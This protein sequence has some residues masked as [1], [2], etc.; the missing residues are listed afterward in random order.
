M[1]LAAPSFEYLFAPHTGQVLLDLYEPATHVATV[2]KLVT[3]LF[4]LFQVWLFQV[5]R[6]AMDVQLVEQVVFAF[7]LNA[8][9]V[10][11]VVLPAGHAVHVAEPALLYDPVAHAVWVFASAGE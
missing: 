4:V 5:F 1:Q 6:F 11:D 2:H 7:V 3:V 9:P 10:P 8:V